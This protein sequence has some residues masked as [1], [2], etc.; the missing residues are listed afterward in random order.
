MS[1]PDCTC[2]S[3]QDM[4]RKPCYPTPPDAEKLI[5]AGFAD[6]LRIEDSYE[7]G[8]YV[9][10]PVF[11]GRNGVDDPQYDYSRHDGCAFLCDGLCELHDLGLKPLEGRLVIHNGHPASKQIPVNLHGRLVDLWNTNRGKRVVSL[12]RE[13][14]KEL[15]LCNA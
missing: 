6:K 1:I 15:V 4:C 2:V 11:K 10:A 5:N 8:V 9:V 7:T 12:L 3:C 14:R 13:K